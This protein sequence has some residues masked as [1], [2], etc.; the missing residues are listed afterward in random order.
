MTVRA[1]LFFLNGD[2]AGAPNPTDA[3]GA[4]VDTV[5]EYLHDRGA[6]E[7]VCMDDRP[8]AARQR[9]RLPPRP[10]DQRRETA[11]G[12]DRRILL[13]MMILAL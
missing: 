10:I 5:G 6:W 12:F 4:S 2:G 3:I 13:R 9:D 8:S 1:N 11:L 7:P